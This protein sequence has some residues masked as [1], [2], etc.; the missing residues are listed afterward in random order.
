MIDLL[1]GILVI[2]T[3]LNCNEH[4]LICA[5][6]CVYS[7]FLWILNTFPEIEVLSQKI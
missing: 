5:Y 6:A 4:L 2:F 3:T 7:G 1:P